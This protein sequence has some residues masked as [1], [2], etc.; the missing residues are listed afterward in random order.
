MYVKLEFFM[1]V[2]QTKIR[3]TY[4]VWNRVWVY[5]TDKLNVELK[6]WEKTIRYHFFVL[7]IF[8]NG[9]R[10]C[11]SKGQ[12]SSSLKVLGHIVGLCKTTKRKGKLFISLLV[13]LWRIICE[14]FNPIWLILA[15]IWMKIKTKKIKE[16]EALHVTLSHY[17][18]HSFL[19]WLFY[20]NLLQ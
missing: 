5:L 3:H 11:S 18:T 4:V 20:P 2:Y 6:M 1:N 14:N 16:Q 13:D 15:E 10:Q 9:T 7:P 19:Q 17:I 8:V 12:R